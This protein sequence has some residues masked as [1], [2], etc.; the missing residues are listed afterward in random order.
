MDFYPGHITKEDKHFFR[1]CLAYFTEDEKRAMLAES[2]AFDAQLIHEK[3][4]SIV[5]ALE[6]ENR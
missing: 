4:D 6:P 5:A 1:P 2:A 3:Y